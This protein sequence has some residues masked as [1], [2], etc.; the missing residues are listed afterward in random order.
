VASNISTGSRIIRASVLITIAHAFFK[1]SGLIQ[2]KIMGHFFGP[3]IIEAVYVTAFEGCV[4][5]LFLIGEEV[6]GPAFLPVFMAEKD[7]RSESAA[8]GLAN[9]LLSVQFLLL[10]VVSA[11]VMLFPDAVIRI[12]TSW[13]I[14][15]QSE[16]F[17]LASNSLIWSAPAL[18]CLSLGSTTYMILNGYKRFFLAALGDAS[19]KIVIALTVLIGANIYGPDHR[20]LVLGI[21]IGSVAKLATHLLGLLKE[22]PRI[23]FSLLFKNPVFRTLLILMLPLVIGIVFAKIRDN[24]NNVWV[25]SRLETDG[26]MQANLYGRKLFG[27]I[28]WL[29]PY[30]L[31]IAMFPFLCEMVER[32]DRKQFSSTVSQSCRM[33]LSMFI[34]IALVFVALAKPLT[35]LIF[36]GGAFTSEMA[37][38][39]AL[40]MA[41]YTLVLPAAAV[42]CLLMQA[43]FA[44]RK[45]IS[46][47][48]VGI[49]FS[50]LSMAISGIGIVIYGLSG[51]SAL[52]IV[53][54]G[55]VLSRTL[56]AFTLAFLLRPH[57]EP[58]T[59][60]GMPLFL[61]R[62]ILTAIV[63]AGLCL[64]AVFAI[65]HFVSSGDAPSLLLAKLAAGGA[66]A[67]VGFIVSVWLLKVEEPRIM[68]TWLI[69]R[70]KMRRL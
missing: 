14:D 33:L 43:F 9:I 29:V 60:S 8:W 38:M 63:S 53:A 55:F 26:L 32:K 57:V 21:V 41:C 69:E 70:I 2:L 31:S 37:S 12:L 28:R 15:S 4:F 20:V 34:P 42:E 64:T 7:K 10:L 5:A 11:L 35:F 65:E 23:R 67:T 66:A 1:V 54:L 22:I 68:L 13:D 59:F 44:Q 39:T 27:A 47:T 50:T 46:I 61:A 51:A 24:Y 30:A 40:S 52:A 18:L 62:T 48:I 36:K 58:S 6:I 45:M 25:L 49:L 56:K 17:H 16:K 19:W 3:R